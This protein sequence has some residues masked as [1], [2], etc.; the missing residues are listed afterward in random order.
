MVAMDVWFDTWRPAATPRPVLQKLA[1]DIRTAIDTREV[2]EQY[3]KPE[4]EPMTLYLADFAKFV[5]AERAK[6]QQVVK[7]ADIEPM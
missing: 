1:G 4:I 5:R 7:R 3:A 6:Y 2:R